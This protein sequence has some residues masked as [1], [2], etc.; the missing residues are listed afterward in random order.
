MARKNIL[1]GLMEPPKNGDTPP[2]RVDAARPRYTTGAIG[3]VSQSIAHLK[4]RA[5][6]D[7]DPRMID[8]AGLKDRLDDDPDLAELTASIGEY[9]QQVPVLLRAQPQ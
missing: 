6:V 3:A 1:K 8:N 2:A 4:A 9:G 5:I 7:I